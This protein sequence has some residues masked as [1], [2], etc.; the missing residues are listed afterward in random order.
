MKVFQRDKILRDVK[1]RPVGR[2][3]IASDYKEGERLPVAVMEI[4]RT[5]TG[6]PVE[7]DVYIDGIKYRPQKD[8]HSIRIG[9]DH[10]RHLVNSFYLEPIDE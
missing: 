9:G 4:P 2:V 3:V 1:G 8:I 7:I 10:L 6:N 5:I